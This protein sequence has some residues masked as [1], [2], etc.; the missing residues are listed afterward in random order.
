M[1]L[2]VA[3]RMVKAQAANMLHWPRAI[4]VSASCLP[5]ALREFTGRI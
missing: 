5:K 4:L 1:E 3:E 2:S